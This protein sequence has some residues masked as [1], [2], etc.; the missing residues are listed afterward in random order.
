MIFESQP[1]HYVTAILY[2]P[3]AKP[4]YPGVLVPC[5]HS[6]NGKARD[7]YQRMPILLAKNG[8]AALCYDPI[9]QGERHQLLGPDGKPRAAA[10][11]LGHSLLGVGSILLGTQYGHVPDLGR[12]AARS[13]ICKAARK[14]IPAA[15]AARASPAGAR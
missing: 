7:L 5:G 10:S 9:D 1:R 15:S 14:S 4:P 8:M 13:T 2:L 11:T 12:H 3:D 6:A